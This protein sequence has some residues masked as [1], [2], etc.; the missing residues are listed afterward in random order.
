[1]IWTNIVNFI[2]IPNQKLFEQKLHIC[3]FN[4]NFPIKA[5]KNSIHFHK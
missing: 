4:W 5:K 1:M 3:I 2:I